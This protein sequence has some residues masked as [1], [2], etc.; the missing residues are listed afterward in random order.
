MQKDRKM[1]GQNDG[2]I[3]RWKYRKR[4]RWKDRK[5]ER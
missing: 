3:V 5:M 4:T 2:K 1:D